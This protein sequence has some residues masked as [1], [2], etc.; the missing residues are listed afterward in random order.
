MDYDETDE[1][2]DDCKQR[3]KKI[4]GKKFDTSMIYP[5]SQFE[6]F[7]GYLWGHNKHDSQLTKEERAN[8]D[9]WLK[10]RENILNNGH[11]QKNNAFSELDLHDVKWNRYQAVL[12]P[13]DEYR[14][15]TQEK[16]I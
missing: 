5:L 11:R 2:K 7:F 9:K 8:K 16:D 1:F 14:K 12:L 6:E 10:C 13:L 3:L 4:I 15:L